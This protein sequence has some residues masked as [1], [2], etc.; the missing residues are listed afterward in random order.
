MRRGGCTVRTSPG[1]AV[2]AAFSESVAAPHLSVPVD[3]G[4]TGRAR[5]CGLRSYGARRRG[6][7]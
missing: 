1:E 3:G 7:I 5:G 2:L 6:A 4:A